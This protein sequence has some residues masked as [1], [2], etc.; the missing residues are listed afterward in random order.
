V[1]DASTEA[2]ERQMSV[3]V[4]AA[5]TAHNGTTLTILDCPASPVRAGRWLTR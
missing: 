3:E 4:N 1:G 2:R 5:T